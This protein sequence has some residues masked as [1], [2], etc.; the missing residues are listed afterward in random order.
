MLTVIRASLVTGCAAAIILAGS[1]WAFA[2]GTT[3]GLQCPTSTCTVT[4][5][6]SG[7]SPT[8]DPTTTAANSGEG[9]GASDP[10]PTPSPTQTLSTPC[11]YTADPTYVPS[12]GTDTHA[13]QKGAWYTM[14]CVDALSSSGTAFTST[15]T[16]VWL[17]NP[18][19]ASAPTPGQLAAQAAAE[20]QLANPVIGSSPVPGSPEL[21]GVPMWVW[22]GASS[23]SPRSATATAAGVSVTATAIPVSAV[24]SFGDGTSITCE[25]P[26]TVYSPADGA[27]TSSPTCGHTYTQVGQFTLT[28]TITWNV[29]WAGAGQAGQLAGLTT[30]ATEPVTVERSNAVV[31]N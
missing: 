12:A 9:S 13:G 19:P 24:W 23:W 30:T 22:A 2:D 21:I 27:S 3:G 25:G 6:V 31:T 11:T 29:T 4:V 18:P 14:S 17:T 10:S 5:T 26:G 7:S 28:A 1:T 15:N 16:E 20:L 8:A